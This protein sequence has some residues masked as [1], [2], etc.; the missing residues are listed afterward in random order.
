MKKKWSLNV[1]HLDEEKALE[2][3]GWRGG[4]LRFDGPLCF[5][6]DTES[7]LHGGRFDRVKVQ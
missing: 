6:A 7:P 4:N 2:D 3:Y 1:L 5:R